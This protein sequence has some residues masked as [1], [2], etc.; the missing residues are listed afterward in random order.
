MRTGA[1][2]CTTARRRSCSS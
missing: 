2:L 1:V